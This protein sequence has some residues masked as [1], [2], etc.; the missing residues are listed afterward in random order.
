MEDSRISLYKR[1]KEIADDHSTEALYRSELEILLEREGYEFNYKEISIL[2]R[3]AYE[4][5]K[6]DEIIRAAFIDQSTNRPLVDSG[7]AIQSLQS[8]VPEVI[9]STIEQT[10]DNTCQSLSDLERSLNGTE[11]QVVVD[12]S[13]KLMNVIQGTANIVKIQEEATLTFQKFQDLIDGYECAKNDLTHLITD[14]TYIRNSI[15]ESYRKYSSQLLDLFGDKIRVIAPEIFDFNE[16]EWLDVEAINKSN[17]LQ[18]HNLM[19][20]SYEIMSLVSQN[21]NNKS[22]SVFQTLGA[23]GV[24]NEVKGILVAIDIFSH[25]ADAQ[26]NTNK[27]KGE[28]NSF[29]SKLLMDRDWIETDIERLYAIYK[30]INDVALYK[31]Y[32]YTKKQSE[33]L[34]VGMSDLITTLYNTPELQELNENREDILSQIKD[35]EDRLA[36]VEASVCAYHS[37]AECY[38]HTITNL[39]PLYNKSLAEKP[40]KPSAI[41]N[42]ITFGQKKKKYQ[43]HLYLW[44]SEYYYVV[45]EYQDAKANYNYFIS[46]IEGLEKNKT[47]IK[48][49]LNRLNKD[50][51]QL[52][53]LI[54]EKIKPNLELRAQ[55]AG[56]L[57]DVVM[58]LRLAREIADTKIDDSLL[59][60]VK[61]NYNDD[62]SIKIEAANK[63]IDQFVA[64]LQLSVQSVSSKTLDRLEENKEFVGLLKSDLHEEQSRLM[65]SGED[66]EINKGF[67]EPTDNQVADTELQI[68]ENEKILEFYETDETAITETKMVASY[69]ADATEDLV[70]LLGSYMKLY[71]QYDVNRKTREVYSQ[72]LNPLKEKFQQIIRN[73]DK[74]SQVLSDAVAKVNLS[75]DRQALSKAFEELSDG[76]I[77]LSDEDIEAFL[78]GNHTIEL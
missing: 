23:K 65:L 61:V 18:F 5:F 32:T 35:I 20:S 46:Q 40:K 19:N 37:N 77:R 47:I 4:F 26:M 13:R 71:K 1:I 21:F 64:Q 15:I 16:I 78:N 36:D 50:L 29:V 30:S 59:N 7:A 34:E 66:S 60:A 3:E 55:V 28:F 17:K 54:F 68:A 11:H 45:Q 31:A 24:S 27:L 48:S 33:V 57:K 8:F 6:R 69:T 62:A 58:M 49:D 70:L 44:N 75:T 52:N 12:G 38:N 74:Q 22:K 73:T 56:K 63:A 42:V 41:V 25:Y 14:F 39:Q 51:K 2:V 76:D 43:E 72:A 53:N 9:K 10:L 67:I